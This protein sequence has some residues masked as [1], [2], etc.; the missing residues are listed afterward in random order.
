MPPI[1]P[2]AAAS[3]KARSD[4]RLGLMPINCAAR[5]LMAQARSALPMMV[6][7]KNKAK[8]TSTTATTPQIQKLW[9]LMIKAPKRRVRSSIS[10]VVKAGTK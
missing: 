6:R 7:S 5:R 1:A 8:A 4:M 9:A 3:E 2:S 10:R